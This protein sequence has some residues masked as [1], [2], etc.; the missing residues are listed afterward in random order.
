MHGL[1]R[2]PPAYASTTLAA[3]DG[4][5][6]AQLWLQDQLLRLPFMDGV[7]HKL[8]GTTE[9]AEPTPAAPPPA[10]D[11]GCPVDPPVQQQK[12]K[13]QDSKRKGAKETPVAAAAAEAVAPKVPVRPPP[14]KLEPGDTELWEAFAVSQRAP[15]A[16]LERAASHGVWRGALR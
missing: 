10:A 9:S 13:K 5:N 8:R 16:H 15:L 4:P 1:V 12:G 7:R 14:S 3:P 2:S 6:G 11:C